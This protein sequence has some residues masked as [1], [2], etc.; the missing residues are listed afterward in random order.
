VFESRD[1]AAT[2][3][4]AIVAARDRGRALGG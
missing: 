1:L 2:V 3:V 4:D